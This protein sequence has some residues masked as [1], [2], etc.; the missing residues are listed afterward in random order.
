[1]RSLTLYWYDGGNKLPRPEPIAGDEKLGDKGMN[2]ALFIGGKGV[3]TTGEDDTRPRL[4][5]ASKRDEY[6]K[7]TPRLPCIEKQRRYR[8]WIRAC[9]GGTPACSNLDYVAPI[10]EVVMLGNRSLRT[11]TRFEWAAKGM[12][13]IGEPDAEPFIKPEYRD[14]WCP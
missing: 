11:G 1:M 4:L 13:A 14:G 6:L 3:L 8:D 7:A 12:K 9:K 10:T 5:P 2:A